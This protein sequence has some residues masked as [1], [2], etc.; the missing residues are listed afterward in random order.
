[1]RLRRTHARSRTRAVTGLVLAAGLAVPTVIGTAPASASARDSMAA[2]LHRLRMCESGD[3]YREN[4]HNGYFGAYQFAS[5]TW[6]SL[7]YSGLPNHAKA[8]TQDAAATKL[9]DR[10]GWHAWPSCAARE[11]LAG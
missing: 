6:H 2:K 9:H 11:H 7:G 3:S 8:A 5:S 4:T 10:A 1:M